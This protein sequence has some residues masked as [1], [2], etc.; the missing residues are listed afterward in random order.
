[1]AWEEGKEGEL[2]HILFLINLCIGIL[3]LPCHVSKVWDVRGKIRV[4]ISIGLFGPLNRDAQPNLP[5][6][7]YLLKVLAADLETSKNGY[8]VVSLNVAEMDT[9]KYNT[10]EWL[11]STKFNSYVI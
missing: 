10:G 9:I 6:Y 8:H 11:L 1:M 5:G 3:I 7:M 4:S 2:Q